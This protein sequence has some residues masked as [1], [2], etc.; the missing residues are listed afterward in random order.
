MH[1]ERSYRNQVRHETMQSFHIAVKETDLCI[2]ASQ[3]MDVL[4]KELVLECRA[5]IEAYIK[6]HPAFGTTLV[7]WRMPNP[8]PNIIAAMTAA[9]RQAGVGPMAAIAGAISEYVGRGLLDH[10]EEVIVE[11]GGDVFI[12]CNEP[13]TVG[14]YA[15]KSPL[16]LRVGLRVDSSHNPMA[17]CTSSGTVGPSLSLG[18]ADAVSIVSESCA[19]ADAAATAIG[20]RVRTP[21]DIQDAIAYGQK[22][23][24][25]QAILVILDDKLG[26]WGN[27]DIIPLH[28]KKG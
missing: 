25:V 26:V 10:I 11:N 6:N 13:I 8:A 7:P 28:G 18:Q 5:Y 22:I 4:A 21:T 24:G 20:N 27:I 15:G 3:R 19:L 2:H 12:K 23:E 9:G 14:V 17:V 16:S 1:Q